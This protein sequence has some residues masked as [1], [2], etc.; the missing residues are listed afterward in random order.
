MDECY[1]C[2]IETDTECNECGEYICKYHTFKCFKCNNSVCKE[3]FI[4]LDGNITCD[5][6]HD[7]FGDR[8]DEETD[9]E[10][11]GYKDTGLSQL[12]GSADSEEETMSLLKYPFYTLAGITIGVIFVPEAF[13]EIGLGFLVRSSTLLFVVTVVM[14]VVSLFIKLSKTNTKKHSPVQEEV[15]NTGKR[16][17]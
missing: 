14:G 3:S 10:E 16:S 7:E 9:E 2:D 8:D 4:N 17:D 6:C 13:N 12:F 1:C 15:K 11:S 5:D